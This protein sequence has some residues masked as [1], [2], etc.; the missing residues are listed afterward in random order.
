VHTAKCALKEGR[1]VLATEW[2]AG[3]PAGGNRE[4]LAEGAKA[5]RPSGDVVAGFEGVCEGRQ[6]E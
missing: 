2:P 3:H 1:P 6:D 4:L 5:L